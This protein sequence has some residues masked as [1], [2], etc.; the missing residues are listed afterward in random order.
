MTKPPAPPPRDYAMNAD[1]AAEPLSAQAAVMLPAQLL[2]PGEIIILL[3]KPS[4][5]FIVLAPL[6]TLIII[7]LGVLLLGQLQARGI[8]LGL[9]HA[10]LVLAGSGLI[11]ARLF[12]QVLEWLNQI[13]VLTDQRVIRV[14]GVLNVRVFE[15]PLQNIQQTDLILPLLQRLFGLGTLG[16]ATAGTAFHEAYW[17]MLSRP[18]D[19]HQKV[20]ETLRR[21]RR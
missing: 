16:F 10:D 2:Q 9:S 15:C 8:N 14:R 5:L 4:P 6:R 21:Y 13:Y 7:L 12:W 3:L 11:G 20:V 1:G 18:L 17:L 19:V